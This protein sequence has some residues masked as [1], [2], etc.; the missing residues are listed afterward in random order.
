VIPTLARQ[1][2]RSVVVFLLT[3]L[4]TL[5]LLSGCSGIASKTNTSAP[6]AAVSM[7]VSP[8][9]SSVQVSQSQTFTATVANDSQNKGVNWSLS[10]A[11]CSGVECGTLS[12]SSSGSGAAITYT[13]PASAP[14]PATVTLTATSAADGTKSVAA[15]ITLTSSAALVVTVSPNSASIPAGAGAKSFTATVQNDSQNKGVTWVL[16]GAGCSGVACGTLS[17]SS[18]ASGAA[19]TYMPPASAPSPAIVTLTATSIS[20]NTK[21][22]AAVL[23]V[24]AQAAVSVTVSPS[25]A[26]V[27]SGGGTK[28]FTATLQ[29]DAQNKGVTWTL[30]GAGCSGSTCG[31]L[32]ATSSAS[33]AAITYTAPAT[34][35]TPATLTLTATS[36]SDATKTGSATITVTG[37]PVIAVNLSATSASL[38]IGGTQNFTA[39][40]QNDSQNKGVTWT[41]SGAGCSAATCGGLSATSS[42]SGAAIVYTA[43]SSVPT[44]P[45]ITLTATSVADGPKSAAATITVTPPSGS[46]SVALTPKRGG[47]A[48]SQPLTFTASVA[49]DASGAGVTWSASAGTFSTQ[50]TTSATYVAPASAGPVTITATSKADVTK[51]ASAAIG[52]TDLAGVTTYHNNLSRDGVN[53][54]EF[55]LTTVNVTTATFGKVFSCTID[56]PA[57]AQPLW[58][59]NLMIGGGTHNVILAASSH[60]T[61]YAFDADANPC[62]MY[63][64]K[65]LMAAGETFLSN[66]DVGSTDIFTDIGIVGT[67][68]IDPSS[69]TLYVV[70]KSKNQGGSCSPS[71]SCHQRLHALSL[72]DGSEKFG[73]PVDIASSIAV[74]GTGDGSSGGNLPFDTLR[75]NQRPGLALVNGIVYVAWASHG[76]NGP[77]HGWVIAFDKTTLSRVAVFNDSPNGRQGGIWMSGGAPASD[78]SGNLY[79]TTGNGDFDG[80]KDFG[81]SFLKLSTSSGLTLAD[82][83]TPFDQSNLDGGDQDVGSGAAVLVDLPSGALQHLLIGG[84]KAGSG[85]AGNLYV[86]NRDSMGRHQSG[87]NSQ[88]VQEFPLGNGIFGTAVFWKNTLY[89]AGAGGPVK[90][91]ALDTS[92]S[93]FNPASTSRSSGSFGFPGSTPSVSA[94]GGSNGIVWALDNSR[95]GTPCCSNGPAILHAYDASNLAMELWNSTQGSG[96]TA[97]NAVKFTVPTVANG[98]V[99]VGTRS[100]IDVYALLP[101]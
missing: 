51:S 96:N 66:N 3:S 33:G 40:V 61:V 25:T 90:A 86:L 50:S 94:S 58:V 5:A 30:S 37:P 99:Y 65:Q 8:T 80:S 82:F 95:Y 77:Y 85:Q 44:P 16:S 49:N 38:P 31:S 55:A 18:S 93:K 2:V 60:N 29:N 98:K 45:T 69:N 67:P 22:A 10:G 26:S 89:L 4:A 100:E 7:S 6:A 91:F 68:V 27:Q 57:Y 83:F 71:S 21:S 92:T 81:D 97:G 34:V 70:S 11:G 54:Q 73:G 75:E 1:A 14:T 23:T 101:N 63:W 35:P 59:P 74:P 84:G 78:S 43:P 36:V 53:S 20:D 12:A 47:L 62:V 28:S 41:L 24:T 72:A 56:S 76:D 79:M 52:V 17:A 46:L 32:S 13:A 88:I 87:N 64:S 9:A 39:T 42:A 48:L 19:I 15:A